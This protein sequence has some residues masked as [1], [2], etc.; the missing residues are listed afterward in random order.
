[1]KPTARTTTSRIFALALAASV[2]A[3]AAPAMAAVIKDAAATG[4]S[5][6]FSSALQADTGSVVK[7]G[8]VVVNLADQPVIEKST[9]AP[10]AA[11]PVKT[12]LTT[13]STKATA[14]VPKPVQS[15]TAAAQTAGKPK[16]ADS[17]STA[18]KR[19]TPTA[20]ATPSG[21]LAEAQ[22]I[23]A[24]LIAKY[25]ILAGTTVSFG[26]TP[27]GHEAVAYYMSGR[28]LISSSHTVGLKTIL[29]HEVW[30]IIDWRDN[31][32][33]DWGENVPPK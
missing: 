28:I 32:R 26:T 30:H 5:A 27:N 19:T 15:V 21:D 33:I 1:M 11:K 14:V 25:P 9:A 23:L 13:V 29:N 4:T 10:V 16:A 6:K 8:T 2:M 3:G 12:A 7:L 18:V 24:G 17:S 22:A 20:T 31:G